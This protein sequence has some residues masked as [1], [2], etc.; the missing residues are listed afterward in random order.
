MQSNMPKPEYATERKGPGPVAPAPSES[1]RNS[2]WRLIQALLFLLTLFALGQV[3]AAP[4]S[5]NRSASDLPLGT[6]IQYF[7]EGRERLG[8][9]QARAVFE[10]G[11]AKSG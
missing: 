3:R 11:E 4:V 7:Q 6:A 1:R 8:L 10:R 9:D 2:P 5:L